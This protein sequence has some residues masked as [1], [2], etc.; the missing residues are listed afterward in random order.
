[1]NVQLQA[2]NEKREDAERKVTRLEGRFNEEKD[3]RRKIGD[4]LET[5]NEKI[6]EYEKK[7]QKLKKRIEQG[8][9]KRDLLE[10][11]IARENDK[12]REAER[13]IQ[14]LRKELEKEKKRS[15]I[16][17]E[18]EHK[19]QEEE[20]FDAANFESAKKRRSAQVK[21]TTTPKK[22]QGLNKEFSEKPPFD[23]KFPSKEAAYQDFTGL[24]ATSD[25]QKIAGRTD[26]PTIGRNF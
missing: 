9:N 11:E 22:D 15:R 23:K 3:T 21:F 7:I 4:E 25:K 26:Y 12:R 19:Y 20:K 10:D 13:T 2:A 5:A 24:R 6:E 1:M 18:P 14:M 17:N 16:F 8:N